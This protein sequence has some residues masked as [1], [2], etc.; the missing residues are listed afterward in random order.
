MN[1]TGKLGYVISRQKGSHIRIT[2]QVQGTHHVTVPDHRPIKI[3]TLAAILR[4]VGQHHG[5]DREALLK[6]LF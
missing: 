3:G 4:D 2:T 6:V 5:M 1:P